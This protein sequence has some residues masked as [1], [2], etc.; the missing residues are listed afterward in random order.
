MQS[1]EPGTREEIPQWALDRAKDMAMSGQARSLWNRFLALGKASERDRITQ[2][3]RESARDPIRRTYWYRI[4]VID[5]DGKPKPQ[6]QASL[7]LQW[8]YF[9]QGEQEARER[10][11]KR[12]QKFM[13]DHGDNRNFYQPI[14]QSRYDATAAWRQTYR[15]KPPPKR[16]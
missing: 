11:E 14:W 13:H 1:T 9:L 15:W 5:K 2:A 4:G 7:P 10:W 3:L 16:R 6:P 12:R 8:S